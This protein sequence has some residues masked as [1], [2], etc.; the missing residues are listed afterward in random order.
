MLFCGSRSRSLAYRA[1]LAPSRKSDSLSPFLRLQRLSPTRAFK[2][3]CAPDSSSLL[4]HH[5]ST[6]PRRPSNTITR[7]LFLHLG[8]HPTSPAYFNF[9]CHSRDTIS[10][11]VIHPLPSLARD[12]SNPTA[13]RLNSSPVDTD[14]Q[15]QV[16]SLCRHSIDANISP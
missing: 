14:Q 4:S 6:R 9:F 10:P 11:R 1:P 16:L 5:S 8:A 2:F 3:S 15:N 13:R 12:Q 7:F